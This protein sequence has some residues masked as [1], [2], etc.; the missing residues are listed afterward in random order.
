MTS[1]YGIITE[2]KKRTNK[3]KENKKDNVERYPG[4]QAKMYTTFTFRLWPD[5][6][7]QHICLSSVHNF[8][9]RLDSNASSPEVHIELR[10][11]LHL[12]GLGKTSNEVESVKL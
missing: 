8:V 11:Y 1:L 9:F 12:N 6:A 4:V 5:R 10:S 3:A 7:K 2:K